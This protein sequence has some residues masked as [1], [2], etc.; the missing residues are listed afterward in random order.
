MANPADSKELY[1]KYLQFK[2]EQRDAES[3]ELKRP[4][5]ASNRGLAAPKSSAVVPPLSNTAIIPI[6]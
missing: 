5:P 2:Q 6:V 4:K 1:I 3:K